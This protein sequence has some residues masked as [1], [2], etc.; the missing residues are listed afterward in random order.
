MFAASGTIQ[1]GSYLSRILPFFI[2]VRGVV[3]R[4]NSLHQPLN[5]RP[6]YPQ[7]PFNHSTNAHLT[8]SH[9][10]PR[11]GA[12]HTLSFIVEKKS[13]DNTDMKDHKHKVHS[14]YM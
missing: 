7:S 1:M 12:D 13:T 4:V 9:H 5:Q 11:L 10:S 2:I 3:K 8:H 14:K 6:P